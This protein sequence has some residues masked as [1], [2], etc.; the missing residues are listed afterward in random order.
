MDPYGNG[1][2]V[3]DSRDVRL[4]R[5]EQ[6]SRDAWNKGETS[7]AF[8]T[9]WLDHG[10]APR[11]DGYGSERYHYAMLVQ[12]SAEALADYA[13]AAP[14]RVLMQNHQAHILEHL[15]QKTMAYA[16]FETDWIIPHG[17]L[18]KTDTPVMAMVKEAG[19][20]LLLSLADP[21]LRLPK[22][23]NMGYLDEEANSTPSRSS[24]V[25]VELRGD[26][27]PAPTASGVTLEESRNGVTALL[28]ECRDGATREV[29]LKRMGE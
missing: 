17:I 29:V 16:L 15:G 6:K 18:R 2:F 4:V 13:K 10:Q 25:R 27:Q 9:C 5:G 7:G 26:W 3:P 21:D 8:S 19:D 23:R 20:G 22:R 24:Q 14:Y 11:D 28:F 1:Y 12:T